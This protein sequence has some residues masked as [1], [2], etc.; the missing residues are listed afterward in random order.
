MKKLFSLMLTLV[1]AAMLP[2]GVNAA[3]SGAEIVTD[4]S[5][6]I[7][8]DTP[9]SDG[10]KVCHV[11]VKFTGEGMTEINMRLTLEG[12]S[13]I[14]NNQV[15]VP[16][17]V[18]WSVNDD[19]K[20]NIIVTNLTGSFSGESELFT[21]TLVPGTDPENCAAK[22]SLLNG[23]T[24]TKD[25]DTTTDTPTENKQ[26]GVTLPYIFLGGALLV[27]GYLLISTKN[28]SKMYKI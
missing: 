10:S 2:F 11:K 24:P 13:T 16:D 23:S 19:D 14:K 25:D 18:S 27:A 1:V 3:T 15:T 22:I 9:A 7:P 26:T 28:K 4:S 8:C 6:N 20:N 12:G 21:F 17:N 5:G